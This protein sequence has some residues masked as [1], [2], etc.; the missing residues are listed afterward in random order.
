LTW[1]PFN[2]IVTEDTTPFSGTTILVRERLTPTADGT[3]L[4]VAFSKGRGGGALNRFMMNIMTRHRLPK[5]I[6]GSMEKMR[7]ELLKDHPDRQPA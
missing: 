4:E 7:V 6:S 5:L 2:L 1:R 3:C